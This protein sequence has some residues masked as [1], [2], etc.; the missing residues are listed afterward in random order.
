M[1]SVGHKGNQIHSFVS[2]C[3]VRPESSPGLTGTHLTLSDLILSTVSSCSLLEDLPWS[4]CLK[5]RSLCMS[6]FRITQ[7]PGLSDKVLQYLTPS[8]SHHPKSWFQTGFS[9]FTQISCSRTTLAIRLSEA[10]GYS[11]GLTSLQK[12]WLHIKYP[13]LVCHLTPGGEKAPRQEL[14]SLLSLS[15]WPDP[16][17]TGMLP[18]A[19]RHQR[20]LLSHVV[21]EQSKSPGESD[22]LL[23]RRIRTSLTSCCHRLRTTQSLLVHFKLSWSKSWKLVLVCSLS[24]LNRL[25]CRIWFLWV[26]SLDILQTLALFYRCIQTNRRTCWCSSLGEGQGMQSEKKE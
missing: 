23:V 11:N 6:Y 16:A 18:E 14:C 1:G 13:R 4:L 10:L 24:Y 2:I 12:Y 26:T 7:A 3:P 25:F 22:H 5:Y 15:T 9:V 17:P 8:S 20:A 19:G 21:N